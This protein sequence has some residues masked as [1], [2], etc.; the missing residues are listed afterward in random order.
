MAK[1]REICMAKIRDIV[2]IS[3]ICMAKIRDFKKGQNKVTHT[4]EKKKVQSLTYF[5][6]FPEHHLSAVQS[7]ALLVTDK[8]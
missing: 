5:G 3:E 8:Y 6:T 4:Y 7:A 2:K 1:I